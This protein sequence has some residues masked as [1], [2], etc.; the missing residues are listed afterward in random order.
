MS[1]ADFNKLIGRIKRSASDSANSGIEI[2]DVATDL[3]SCAIAANQFRQA[4]K[5]LDE[6]CGAI[7]AH[8]ELRQK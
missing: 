1:V 3:S 5:E 2:L 8:N 6:L 7:R 4:A